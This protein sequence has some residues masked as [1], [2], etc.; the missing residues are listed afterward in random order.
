MKNLDRLDRLR[1]VRNVCLALGVIALLAAISSI[2]GIGGG[3]PE[4]WSSA[5][6]AFRTAGYMRW[7]I[8]P[9][10][11]L[12]IILMAVGIG[13]TVYLTKHIRMLTRDEVSEL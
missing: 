5:F 12:G 8:L 9:L 3:A 6:V 11:V 2:G 13:L 7:L 4:S 10:F 1:N